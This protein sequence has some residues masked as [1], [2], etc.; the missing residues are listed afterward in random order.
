ML[1]EPQSPISIAELAGALHQ[2]DGSAFLVL[3][4]VLRRVIK[5]HRRV[6]GFG[7][8]VPHRKTFVIDRAPLLELVD[9]A[10]LLPE[11][12][13][14]L[15]ETVLLI[16][17]PDTDHL[18]SNPA[19]EALRRCWQ[20]LFHLRVHLTFEQRLAHRQL[21][22]A[23]IRERIH[24]IGQTEFDEIRAVLRHEDLLLPPADT[25]QV[26]I[27][28]A[29]VYLELRF[30]APRVLRRYF[31]T[32]D[33]LES[34]DAILA[35]DVDADRLFRETRLP[36]ADLPPSL[37]D[38]DD[39]DVVAEA[40]MS[41][42]AAESAGPCSPTRCSHW[43][44]RAERARGMGNLVRSAILCSRA[45]RS[46]DSALAKRARHGANADLNRFARRLQSAL[47]LDARSVDDWRRMLDVLLAQTP[48]GIWTPE[49][50][51]LYDLQ[52]V[53][54]DHES[55]IFV[56]DIVEWILT[57]GRRPIK[58]HLPR[59]REVLMT[60]HLR[61]AM[62]RV[63]VVRIADEERQ[64]LAALLAKAEH[65]V[66]RR[67][68]ELFRPP[69]HNA[70]QEVGLQPRCLPETVAKQKLIEELLDLVAE[71]GYLTLGDLRDALAR[72]NLKIP[73]VCGVGD[74]LRRDRLLHLD[75][76]LAGS[77]DGV[78]RRAEVYL[79]WLQ[80]ISSAGFGTRCGRWI[81]QFLA[82]PFGGAFLILEGLQHIVGPLVAMAA[83]VPIH[84][85]NNATWLI[86]GIFI[87]ELIHLP[88][89]RQSV[90]NKL[91]A[92]WAAVRCVV[93]DLPRGFLAL[94]LVRGILESR[95]GLLF[96]RVVLKPLLLTVI[97]WLL[98]PT[99]GV[100]TRTWSLGAT[101]IFLT[102]SFFL[103]SP[104]GRNLEE[105]VVDALGRTWQ[106]IRVGLLLGLFRLIFDLFNGL[107]EEI[108]RLLYTVDEWFRFKKGEQRF[109][110][111]FKPVL[112]T[113]W[114]FVNYAIRVYINLLI[115]PQINPIKHFPV[116][117]V[118]HKLMLPFLPLLTELLATPLRPLG[119]VLATTI[120]GA[121]VF[122]LPGVFGFLVWELKENW[123]LY[124]GNRSRAL[125]PV[126]IGSHGE[127]MIRFMKP[128][129]HSGTLP[130]L[131][132]RLRRAERKSLA[133][134]TSKR[135]RKLRHALRHVEHSL[136]HF[137]DR[138][139]VVLLAEGPASGRLQLETGQIV[140]G[141]NRIRVELFCHE[142]SQEPMWL[143]FEEQSGSLLAGISPT[144]WLSMIHGEHRSAMARALAGLYKMSGV[145]LVR[146]QL[147]ACFLPDHP[148]YDIA[149][150]GLVVWP[151]AS[152][153]VEV[154]YDLRQSPLV[155]PQVITGAVDTAMPAL[156]SDRILFRRQ[157]LSWDR[158]VQAWE[159]GTMSADFDGLDPV[160]LL[161]Q[162]PAA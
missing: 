134:N 14:R 32:I 154:L 115:E 67:M 124:A 24:R 71:R 27:E 110:I 49:A 149:D 3:P 106:R 155:V 20:L 83:G 133:A 113:L 75:N 22:P 120:A 91:R 44:S 8:Q 18:V 77:L 138:E 50:R 85:M 16:A 150:A 112:G 89:F 61:S 68:R 79:R 90:M 58:R 140:V 111:L 159:G 53:C 143:N 45:T 62:N 121:T 148:A 93:V 23:G 69:L 98:L 131:F 19:G 65:Q 105:I 122:L 70:L 7:L 84:L 28:F 103:N 5:Q 42:V 152:Y 34:I 29:A 161:P 99:S 88:A 137:V 9:P 37:P 94:P 157:S 12:S 64:D 25:S 142:Y 57:L 135:I 2:A 59:Q 127:T 100:S 119:T 153:D 36:A 1:E 11:P 162:D 87:L 96:Y 145:D 130:K 17:A 147:E 139:L 35:E 104:T 102:T 26:Y 78:Y 73:D 63:P 74:L 116:V 160:S 10:E 81:V 128:G 158:W 141:S 114:Y 95:W 118:S 156:E 92:S 86:N 144:G 151:S 60:R 51:L 30:F 43:M 52:K 126:M 109:S 41:G 132:A 15:P 40:T 38:R 21:T 107:L 97:I 54:V 146:E 31:P 13:D 101:A 82:L 117:T 125:E 129:F 72:N 108:D 46:S 55:D 76:L 6:A 136:R 47:E 123:R 48:N 80:K 56:I 4:R 66:E 39:E 33:R